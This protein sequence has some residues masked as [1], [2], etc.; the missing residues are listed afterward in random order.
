MNWWRN[1]MRTNGMRITLGRK[2][3]RLKTKMIW[4]T[5]AWLHKTELILKTYVTE[6]AQ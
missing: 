5:C 6:D 4:T 1:L 3:Y 2:G